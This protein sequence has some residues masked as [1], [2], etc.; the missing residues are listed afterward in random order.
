MIVSIVDCCLVVIDQLFSHL[1]Q[2]Q[3]RT[4]LL[5]GQERIGE[6]SRPPLVEFLAAG[7]Q[8]TL[9]VVMPEK[10]LVMISYSFYQKV[11]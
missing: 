1:W 4:G 6:T 8:G 5:S 11:R 9:L 7:F 2:R 10:I 3:Q